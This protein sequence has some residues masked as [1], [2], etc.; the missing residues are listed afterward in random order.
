[1]FVLY[2]PLNLFDYVINDI[3]KL[4]NKQ[5]FEKM[6]NKKHYLIKSLALDPNKMDR[7]TYNSIHDFLTIETTAKKKMVDIIKNGL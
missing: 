2:S 1:M 5:N 3:G 6:I 4:S 7:D